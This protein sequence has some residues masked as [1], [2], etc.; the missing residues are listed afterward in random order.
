MVYQ[1]KKNPSLR[2]AHFTL[3]LRKYSVPSRNRDI[4][5]L[6]TIPANDWVRP[7]LLKILYLPC[8]ALYPF[9]RQAS[10]LV[11]Y[12][13]PQEKGCAPYKGVACPS[14]KEASFVHK[15]LSFYQTAHFFQERTFLQSVKCDSKVFKGCS[16]LL[17]NAMFLSNMQHA[18]QHTTNVQHSILQCTNP[19][20]LEGKNIFPLQKDCFLQTPV[21]KLYSSG[22]EQEPAFLNATILH[23]CLKM[24][25]KHFRLWKECCTLLNQ[26]NI[27]F[28]CMHTQLQ[29]KW[30][31]KKEHTNNI[32]M[33]LH[34]N[35]CFLVFSNRC[36][37]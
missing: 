7:L 32:D 13:I 18:V 21:K 35:L 20:F 29:K 27:Y 12:S 34:L 3:S 11:P 8:V 19:E 33:M 16:I 5:I 37:A 1:V 36:F 4:W 28:M 25:R 2:G 15:V 24:Q 22:K 10:L 9:N 23:C 26:L 14:E 31:Q 17:E 30:Q 6:W